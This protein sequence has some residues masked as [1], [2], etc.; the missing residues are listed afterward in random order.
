MPFICCHEEWSKPDVRRRLRSEFRDAK[1]YPHVVIRPFLGAEGLQAVRE[2]VQKVDAAEKETDLFRFFQTQDL[3]PRLSKASDGKKQK[4]ANDE[5][6]ALEALTEVFASAGYRELIQ[7]VT[8]CG[9]LCERVD[10]ATQVYTKGSH[11]LCHDDVIGTR[12]VPLVVAGV[13]SK[14][15]Q[16]ASPA[17]AAPRERLH[18]YQ[19][20]S[21]CTPIVLAGLAGVMISQQSKRL[22]RSSRKQ[23][24][25]MEE[26]SH[27]DYDTLLMKAGLR[28]LLGVEEN[29]MARK[30]EEAC[31]VSTDLKRCLSDVE[32]KHKIA[33]DEVEELSLNLSAAQ[34][35]NDA[36]RAENKELTDQVKTMKESA[37]TV[38]AKNSEQWA[39]QKAAENERDKAILEL[40]NVKEQAEAA[41]IEA[42]SKAKSLKAEVE[43]LRAELKETKA[44][45]QKLKVSFIY[46]ITDPEEEWSA[47]EGGALELYSS[48]PATGRPASV[49]T[50]ELLPLADSLA[51][52]L[53]EP[54]VSYHAVREVRGGR[55]RISLQGWLHAPSLETTL[56]FE[57]RGLATLQQILETRA[58]EGGEEEGEVGELSKEDLKVLSDWLA[59]TYLD[60]KQLEAIQKQFEESSYAVLTEFLR[61]DLAER[62]AGELEAVDKADGFE[63]N[64]E[65]LPVPCYTSGV[66]DGWELL[67][68][69]HL[70]R[71]LRLAQAALPGAE[72]PHGRLGCSLLRLAREVFASDSFRRWL[73]ACTGL[74]TKNDGRPQVRRFRPGLDYTVAAR[75]AQDSDEADLDAILCFALGGSKDELQT[76]ASEQ[77]ASEEVGGFECYLAA[78]EEDETV[79]AQEVYRGADTDGPLASQRI[80]V[81][82]MLTVHDHP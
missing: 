32:V 20:F 49:P 82:D 72:S 38:K 14:K 47:A 79:E 75:G 57:H 48:E 41:Q 13:D 5:L 16:M 80:D 21:E 71:F 51:V 15:V 45:M 55:A 29:R 50:T 33:K 64:A 11:L 17:T 7:E 31:Q 25:K 26:P 76:A 8:G 77:W 24:S 43:A 81:L 60:A 74:D 18:S 65:E 10:L 52:F 40:T 2:E 70:R 53:V 54:G 59:P 3:A 9:E 27:E 37:S 42:D 78:D 23:A 6:P 58:V 1:P 12:K 63:P 35:D 73:K 28:N 39:A 68:P 22:N 56:N 34:A 61:A 69:P 62:I 19:R 36:L 66:V 4:L 67:G 46:Y 44:E 30:L